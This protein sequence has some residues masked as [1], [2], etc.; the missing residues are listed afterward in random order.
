MSELAHVWEGSPEERII[1]ELY[2]TSEGGL[3]AG[4]E[5]RTYGRVFETL[6]IRELQVMAADMA[7]LDVRFARGY[8]V[9]DYGSGSFEGASASGASSVSISG[10]P[11]FDVVCY[12]GDVSWTSYDGFPFALVPT[13]FTYGV[14][15]AK[16]TLS[17][18]YLPEDSSRGMNAQFRR[19][20]E[21]L[22][23]LGVD[24]P[25]VVV[26]AHFAG[27]PAGLRRKAAAD[28]V[29]PLGALSEK[30]SAA[31]MAQEGE[32]ERVVE[33]LVGMG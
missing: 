22:D 18:G 5:G 2:R 3:K 6:L 4:T 19:Q 12:H 7:E 15:E 10:S 26:C 21:Y 9:D 28:H 8:V 32:L 33:V 31:G 1:R 29:A 30:G 27:A 25:L 20:R 24:G 17:P 11:R 23:D 16:R 14:I 13:S